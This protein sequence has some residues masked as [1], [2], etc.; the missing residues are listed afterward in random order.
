M[1]AEVVALLGGLLFLLLALVGGGFTVK[2]IIMPTIPKWA[3]AACLLV[4]VTL[5]VVSFVRFDSQPEQAVV[6]EVGAPAASPQTTPTVSATSASPAP[7]FPVVIYGDPSDST[8]EEHGI[9]VSGLRASAQDAAVGVGEQILVE[10]SFENVGTAPVTFGETFI[11][12][13]TPGDDWADTG[14][15]N[16]GA[17]LE[18]GDVLD[19]SSTVPFGAPGTWKLWPCYILEAGSEECPDEWQRFFVTVE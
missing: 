7:G 4:G 5:V 10:F 19:V 8:A 13:R 11:G 2:E 12:V 1:D 6:T 17:V 16:Q 14:A 3:R 15:E 9:Q 18:P